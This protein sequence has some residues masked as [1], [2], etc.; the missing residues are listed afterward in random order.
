MIGY[1]LNAVERWQYRRAKDRVRRLL[2]AKYSDAK[3]DRLFAA[4]ERRETAR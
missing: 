1:L 4:L 2:R 3:I